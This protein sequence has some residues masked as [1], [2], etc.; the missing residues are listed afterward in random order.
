MEID[1]RFTGDYKFDHRY[2]LLWQ[3]IQTQGHKK[4]YPF[5]NGGRS[6]LK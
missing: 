1:V 3:A 2:I 5:A 6:S 4:Y